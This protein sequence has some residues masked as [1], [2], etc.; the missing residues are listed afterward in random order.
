M[1]VH[2][3]SPERTKGDDEV[4]DT[5]IC[6]R[7]GKLVFRFLSSV[8][9]RRDSAEQASEDEVAQLLR[10]RKGELEESNP[11]AA[12]RRGRR[13]RNCDERLEPGPGSIF[14]FCGRGVVQQEDIRQGFARGDRAEGEGSGGKNGLKESE[15]SLRWMGRR[16]RIAVTKVAC[17]TEKR[18]V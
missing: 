3:R 12:S 14:E 2:P 11:Q 5:P 1:N 15:N 18:K 4:G 9:L 16:P 7:E 8:E 13:R 17:E 10:N 6:H